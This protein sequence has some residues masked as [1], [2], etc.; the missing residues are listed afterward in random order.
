MSHLEPI[1]AVWDHNAESMASDIGEQGVKVRQWRNRRNIPASYWDRIIHE[2]A[3]RGVDLQYAQFIRRTTAGAPSND[4]ADVEA[5][6]VLCAT[7]ERRTDDLTTRSCTF[8]DC[9]HT[10]RQAA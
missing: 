9:P 6:T 1:Y 5:R 10:Q 8:V 4:T 3:K 7:C 2:A